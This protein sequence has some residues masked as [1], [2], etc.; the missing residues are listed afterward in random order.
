MNECIV[1]GRNPIDNSEYCSYHNEGFENLR[2]AFEI[3]KEALDIE[4]VEFLLRIQ[5]EEN[6][7]KWARD[8]VDH[9]MQ[10]NDS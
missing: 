2:D 7:G 6:L 3:W 4:W 1:C 8:V 5:E 10:E 9:L